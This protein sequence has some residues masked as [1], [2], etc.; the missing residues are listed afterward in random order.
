MAIHQLAVG[1]LDGQHRLEP[2]HAARRPEIA[3]RRRGALASL[4]EKLASR[5]NADAPFD[6]AAKEHSPA[7]TLTDEDAGVRPAEDAATLILIQLR[8]GPAR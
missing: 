3:E 1:Q 4:T 7:D 5:P 2:R 8:V 6:G